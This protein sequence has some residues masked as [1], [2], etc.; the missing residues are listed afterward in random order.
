[1]SSDN[2]RGR[3]NMQKTFGLKGARA[4]RRIQHRRETLLDYLA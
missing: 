1:L 2:Q 4:G 3:D